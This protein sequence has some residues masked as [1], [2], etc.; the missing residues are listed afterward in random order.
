MFLMFTASYL[1]FNPTLYRELNIRA[2]DLP[3]IVVPGDLMTD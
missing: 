3:R 2:A 1:K